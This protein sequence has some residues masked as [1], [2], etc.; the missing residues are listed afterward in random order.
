M[1]KSQFKS[2]LIFPVCH[3]KA[4]KGSPKRS[5][6]GRANNPKRN[7]K[8]RNGRQQNHEEVRRWTNLTSSPPR[9]HQQPRRAPSPAPDHTLTAD[10]CADRPTR[11]RTEPR[12]SP[13]RTRPAPPSKI[14]SARCLARR[15]PDSV[16]LK[17][18]RE[19]PDAARER[20]TRHSGQEWRKATALKTRERERVAVL[21]Q[22]AIDSTSTV[23]RQKP[24]T[25]SE[26][27]G[28]RLYET[29]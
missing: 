24:A 23:T 13:V 26:A 2:E 25:S 22:L 28:A 4:E 17:P 11:R 20:E 1:T 16:E 19:K 6:R 9:G 8:A 14:T 29:N 3:V 7:T 15:V 10:P 12:P 5:L 21:P 18:R 27:E